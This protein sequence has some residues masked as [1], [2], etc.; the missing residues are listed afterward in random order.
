MVLH[1][2]KLESPSP[3]DAL[4]QV[5]LNLVQWFWRRRY[6]NFVNVFLLFLNYF[7]LDKGG[8]L[9]LNKLQSPS[10][11]DALCQV[12]L[13]LAQWFWR[14][15][16]KK[17]LRQ[18]QQPK[19]GL[20]DF[21]K[22]LNARPQEFIRLKYLKNLGE[23]EASSVEQVLASTSIENDVNAIVGSCGRDLAGTHYAEL[24]FFFGNSYTKTS[25]FWQGN[26]EKLKC[27]FSFRLRIFYSWIITIVKEVLQN[28]CLCSTLT[29]LSSAGRVSLCDTYSVIVSS[30]LQHLPNNS[31]I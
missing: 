4:C 29:I 3:K 31:S 12:W 2:N 22:L 9:Q 14:R 15:K 11:K 26:I 1:L 28:L 16:M 10:P 25:S 19:I 17:C 18:R 30:I 13:R 24:A 6:L 8:A 27:C 20:M 23:S 21:E 5:W 7:P